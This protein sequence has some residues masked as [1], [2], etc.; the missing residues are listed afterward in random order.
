MRKLRISLA[1]ELKLRLGVLETFCL[2]AFPSD[3]GRAGLFLK[4][5]VKCGTDRLVGKDTECLEVLRLERLL[6]RGL[7]ELG[8]SVVRD[9]AATQFAKGRTAGQVLL[10]ALRCG[11]HRPEHRSVSKAIFLVAENA[12][13]SDARFRI[14][15]SDSK[16]TSYW[17]EFQSVAH[18]HA[19]LLLVE[20]LEEDWLTAVD[21]DGLRSRFLLFLAIA[22]RISRAAHFQIPPVGRTSKAA[23][24]DGRRLIDLDR[25]IQVEVNGVT[26]DLNDRRELSTFL[27]DLSPAE[28]TKL[29]DYHG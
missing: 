24:R 1:S 12:A 4:E 16:I 13:R 26:F 7:G 10:Y 18:L 14:P 5:L 27:A 28:V 3:E 9:D 2:M 23:A 21:T 15:M 6:W 29:A 19:A 25:T 22:G 11:V 20:T 8:R 17:K